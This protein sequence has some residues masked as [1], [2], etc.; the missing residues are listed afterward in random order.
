MKWKRRDRGSDPAGTPGAAALD[1]AVLARGC[2]GNRVK[3]GACA[4]AIRKGCVVRPRLIAHSLTQPIV[5]YVKQDAVA[6][7]PR[8]VVFEY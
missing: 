8:G 3:I 5:V 4:K 7:H 1:G 2:F 6:R